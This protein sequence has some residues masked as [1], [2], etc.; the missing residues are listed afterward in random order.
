MAGRQK[1]LRELEGLPEDVLKEVEEFIISLKRNKRKRQPSFRNGK[2]MAKRQ[3][4]AIK[5]WAG[6][7]LGRGFSGKEHDSVLYGKDCA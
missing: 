5:K 7:D 1:I 6:K 2:M 4:A 3:F